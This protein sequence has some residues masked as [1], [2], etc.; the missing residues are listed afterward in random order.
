ME[1]VVRHLDYDGMPVLS[2]AGEADLATVPEL[3]DALTRAAAQH[4][5]QTLVVD[6]DGVTFLDSVAMGMLLGAAR[7]ARSSGGDLVLVCSTPR[8]VEVLSQSRLDRIVE[9]R[10]SV[11][12]VAGATH[13]G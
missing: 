2:L 10:A 9:V 1:L 3:R 7:R 13:H 12:D 6:L 8:V 11:S 5:G 4:P